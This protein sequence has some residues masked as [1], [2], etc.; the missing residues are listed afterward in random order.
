MRENRGG[1][2]N[3]LGILKSCKRGAELILIGD[4]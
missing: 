3:V 1:K 4:P 2:F